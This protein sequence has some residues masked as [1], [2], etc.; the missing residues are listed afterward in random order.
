MAENQNI[1]NQEEIITL[2][3][4]FLTIKSYLNELLRR[5]IIFLLFIA[6]ACGILGAKAYFSKILYPD[7]ITFMINDG[8]SAADAKSSL[9]GS[10]FLSGKGSNSQAK[11]LELFRTKTILYKAL[12]EKI[13]LEKQE[14]YLANHLLD[15][16]NYKEL[17]SPY[18]FSWANKLENQDEFRF[19]HDSIKVFKGVE[20]AM[21]KV[22]Y[23]YFVGNVNV[24]VPGILS[25]NADEE[26]GIMTINLSTE[27]EDLTIVLLDIL[28]KNLSAFYVDRAIEK[29]RK[30][31]KLLEERNDSIKLEL[32]RAEYSLANFNDSHRKLVLLK[33][34]L[35]KIE[36]ERQARLL[37]TMYSETIRAMEESI[38]A[39]KN[40]T[41][42]VQIIDFPSKPISPRKDSVLK[43]LILGF[44]IGFF[45][46]T[47]YIVIAKLYR[48]VME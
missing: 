34:N 37:S 17:I 28:Y 13:E 33:G 8:N 35:R 7:S 5:W 23:E 29:E 30:T 2:K 12:F 39:V 31:Y 25:T 48:D 9:L 21:L 36:L 26:S 3:D 41:P 19:T 27:N 47:V 24:G 40:A 16:L 20:K 14:K 38:F 44:I 6:I 22:L 11:V 10:L 1:T 45:L 18:G 43:G 46:A 32:S 42:Y 4:I 15:Q